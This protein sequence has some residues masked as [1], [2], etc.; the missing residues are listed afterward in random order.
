MIQLDL[1]QWSNTLLNSVLILC[2]AVWAVGRVFE[3]WLN[4]RDRIL[5]RSKTE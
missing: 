3:V 4:V 5:G 2:L 1:I